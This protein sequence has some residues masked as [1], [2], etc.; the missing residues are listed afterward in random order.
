MKGHIQISR[1]LM[2]NALWG[3]SSD[4]LRLFIFILLNVNWRENKKFQF[5]DV[6]VNQGQ[7]LLSYRKIS[8]ANTYLENNRR[9]SW[10]TSKVGRLLAKLEDDGR[11]KILSKDNRLGT[12]IEVPNWRRYQGKAVEKPE[13]IERSVPSP[14]VR[15]RELWETWCSEFANGGRKPKLTQKRLKCLR[16]FLKEQC[17]A[18]TD[19][20][21]LMK[22][23]C[24]AVKN[25]E[26]HSK[27]AYRQIESIF[28]N[29][30]RRERWA[31]NAD[32]VVRH[33]TQTKGVSRDW[34]V[35]D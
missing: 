16:A 28:R 11:I 12:L 32:E 1:S 35:L 26:F 7:V 27:P 23:V 31:N 6:A 29:E 24:Q 5:G 33:Q 22:R 30:E 4:V 9:I 21:A 18:E 13:S 10:T 2:D 34:T 3:Q 20:V 8:E 14:N 15:E 25:S 19:H 17:D